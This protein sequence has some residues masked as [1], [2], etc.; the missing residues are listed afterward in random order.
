[1]LCMTVIVVVGFLHILNVSLLSVFVTV[2]SRNIILLLTSVSKVKFNFRSGLLMHWCSCLV[3]LLFPLYRSN[4]SSTYLYQ[5]IILLPYLLF[6]LLIMWVC[7][8]SWINILARML[9]I[10]EPIGKA[11]GCVQYLL[12]IK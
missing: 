1:M 5:Y 10:G 3:C 12:K 8:I 9:E 7:T 11:S 4:M 2:R 6:C